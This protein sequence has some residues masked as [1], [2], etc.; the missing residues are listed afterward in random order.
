MKNKSLFS[1]ILKYFLV[2]MILPFLTFFLLYGYAENTLEEQINLSSQRMLTQF[3]A[4]VDN[5][6][7]EVSQ[8]C[9]SVGSE[10]VCVEHI[11]GNL[12]DPANNKYSSIKVK[13]ML[14]EY[15]DEK[16]FDVLVYFP[17][18]NQVISARNGTL[19]SQEYLISTYDRQDYQADRYSPLLDCHVPRPQIGAFVGADQQTYL[20]MNMHWS[21]IGYPDREYVVGIVFEPEYLSSLMIQEHLGEDGTLIIY[22]ANKELLI[23]GDGVDS[24]TLSNSPDSDTLFEAKNENGNYVMLSRPSGIVEGYYAYATDLD[25]FWQTLSTLRLFCLIACGLCIVLTVILVFQSTKRVYRP[26][27]AAVQRAA[28]MGEESYDRKE[29]S[30]IEFLS[31]V[32]EKSSIERSDLQSRVRKNQS[33]QHDELVRGLMKGEPEQKAPDR[34]LLEE[35]GMTDPAGQY[36]VVLV[37]IRDSVDMDNDMQDFV[38]TNTFEE[39][40]G[41]NGCGYVV[42]LAAKQYGLLVNYNKD[43]DPEAEMESL[44]SCRAYLYQ[45]LGLDLVLAAGGIH[46][47]MGEVHKSFSEAELALKYMYLLEEADYIDYKDIKN[48]EFSYSSSTESTLSRNMIGFINGKNPQ[49]SGEEFVDEIIKMCN[50][51]DAVSMDNIECF[52]YEMISIINKAFM[53]CG[54]PEG[55]KERIQELVLQPTMASF[56]RELA[57]LL[58]MLRE[59]KQHVSKQETVCQK[60]M[61]YIGENYADTQFSLTQLGDMLN[62]SPYYVSRLFKDKYEMTISD[63]IA[64]TRIQRAK[65]QLINTDLSIKVIA[66]KNGFLSSNIFI[67]TFKKWEGVTPG[68][69]RAQKK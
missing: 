23:S 62:L 24:Y 19:T 13:K 59:M 11:E 43:T 41:S 14:D 37:Y 30:E 67:R 56:R 36:R 3:F 25:D 17:R 42:N 55:R 57:Q 27:D 44:R 32:L 69:Y 34:A 29:H 20:C 26:I 45:Q 39:V 16:L 61:E 4:L 10:S 21:T 54:V 63:C 64:K 51:T 6:M 46:R 38:I 28:Q 31:R 66:E 18:I 15:M 9:I 5:V 53:I 60:V 33:L 7:D 1:Q 49:L 12:K 65:E 50:I 35:I 52:K 48:R 40:S 68:F 47:G 8:T 22:D 2:T 58:E